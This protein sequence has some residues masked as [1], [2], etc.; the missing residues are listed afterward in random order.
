MIPHFKGLFT[1]SKKDIFAKGINLLFISQYG[2]KDNSPFI[3]GNVIVLHNKKDF[4]DFV[5]EK[6]F[7]K[8]GIFI[9]RHN[10]IGMLLV[11]FVSYPPRKA[12]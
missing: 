8:S 6:S 7:L 11:A 2:E 5:S 10:S 12:T 1:A 3:P 9:L 4:P